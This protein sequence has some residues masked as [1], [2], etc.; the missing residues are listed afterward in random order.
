VKD[1]VIPV[2]NPAKGDCHL[3]KLPKNCRFITQNIKGLQAK[4]QGKFKGTLDRIHY[5]QGDI[6]GLSETNTNWGCHAITK[7]F[8][9]TIYW[10]TPGGSL[11]L[12]PIPTSYDKP[13]LPG[14][15]L[16][17]TLGK[18][19]SYIDRKITDSEEL[20]RWTGNS[21][22][23]SNNSKLH[24]I[25]AYRVCDGQA[26]ANSSLTAYNQQFIGIQAKGIKNPNPRQQIIDDPI[27]QIKQLTKTTNDYIMIGIDANAEINNDKRGLG[28]LCNECD[29]V[30]MYTSI[31]EDY[32]NFPTHINGSKR[33]DYILCSPN[34]LRFVNKVGYIKFHEA[35]DSNHR[36]VFCDLDQSLLDAEK[37]DNLQQLECLIGTNSTNHEGE[38]YIR[39]LD[40][41]CK[42]HKLYDKA[43]IIYRKLKSNTLI[44][45]Q[46]INKE[47]NIID[48][49]L[50]EGMLASEK[51][52]RKRKPKTLWSPKLSES[53]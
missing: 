16:T 42:Y 5:M 53:Y 6:I 4:N 25:T 2:Q 24:I 35:M 32:E 49:L 19:R 40:N 51:H 50:T 3:T 26:E 36:A 37:D 34:L 46:S 33:I 39:E 22:R 30:D 41:F 17:L 9:D 1:L 48:K 20:G 14:G 11:T 12:S 47:L 23:L 18:W 15:T 44:D 45:K 43:G 27:L 29:L 52:N 38:K 13:Y 8:K 7:K 21:Y 10:N 31:H 28:K